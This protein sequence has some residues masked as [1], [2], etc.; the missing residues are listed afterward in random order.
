MKSRL[1]LAAVATAL[2][3]YALRCPAVTSGP[4]IGLSTGPDSRL[5]RP[6]P[7]LP[8]GARVGLLT[9]EETASSL[10]PTAFFRGDFVPDPNSEYTLTTGLAIGE[11]RAL[12]AS[13]SASGG[14]P[15]DLGAVQL[16]GLSAQSV[17]DCAD[18][19]G[20]LAC[21]QTDC[22]PLSRGG[23]ASTGPSQEKTCRNRQCSRSVLMELEDGGYVQR[24]QTDRSELGG[25]ETRLSF[26]LLGITP[27]PAEIE[28]AL[29]ERAEILP[30]DATRSPIAIEWR[31]ARDPP[32]AGSF[33]GGYAGFAVLRLTSGTG[34]VICRALDIERRLVLPS[35]VQTVS[36]D[37]GTE[38][39]P[40][41]DVLSGPVT[42]EL[43]RM[44]ATSFNVP[45]F[46]EA[47]TAVGRTT[48]TAAFQ[49]Q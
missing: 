31:T 20:G 33:D 43:I 32:D 47:G 7:D 14:T 25:G 48:R 3:L 38:R 41:R 27:P 29:P 5:G 22:R 21:Q 42:V 10:T 2:A 40:L 49:L 1:L 4:D 34:A 11:C 39:R 16:L 9:L 13:P 30:I 46:V 45:N 23:C 18:C 15:Q 36:G 35:E 17:V 28:V 44:N 24:R 37:G 6:F 26:G 12:D 8:R 19:D